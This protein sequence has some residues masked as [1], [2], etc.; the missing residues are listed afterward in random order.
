MELHNNEDELLRI[1][2][3]AYQTSHCRHNPVMI[4]QT[5]RKIYNQII[6]YS[7]QEE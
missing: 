2:Q 1:S 3:N 5:L 6:A 4:A 7:H